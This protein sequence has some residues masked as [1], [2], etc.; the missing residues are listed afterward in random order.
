MQSLA[1]EFAEYGSPEVLRVVDAERPEPG[2]NEV[3]IAIKA[4]GVNPVD[5]KI[6]AGRRATEPLSA[7]SRLGADAGAIVDKVG[8]DVVGFRVGDAVIARGLRGGYASYAVT[9]PRNLTAKPANMS[10]AQA[11]AVG[12]P[13]GTAFQVLRSAKVASGDIVLIHG[14][15]GAVG[16]AAIQFGVAWGATV[17][18][19]ASTK[20]HDRLRDLG[21]SPVAY[22][23]GLEQR[24]RELAPGGV[25][26][27]LDAAG[28]EEAI[29][30]SLALT[31][32]RGRIVEIVNVGWKEKYGVLAFTSSLP[33]YLGEAESNL[34]VEGVAAMS[35]LFEHGQFDLEIG[36]VF[37]LSDVA[38]AHRAL[39]AG[40][41]RGKIVLVP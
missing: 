5:A 37:P 39:E 28:T 6:R 13:V 41:T 24:V 1:V 22:G 20:N 35:E 21:A 29:Q 26:V 38:E 4:A 11:A 7:P 16:Q 33:G 18:A 19:T 23:P 25:D 32:D 14:G 36:R 3:R 34:R 27:S 31:H 8:T 10:F 30:V 9:T 15:G 40:S 2:H 17:I 12:V